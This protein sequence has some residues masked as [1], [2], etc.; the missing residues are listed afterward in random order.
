MFLEIHLL[1]KIHFRLPVFYGIWAFFDFCKQP[2]SAAQQSRISR[3]VKSI[4]NGQFW[5]SSEQRYSALLIN[6]DGYPRR[7]FLLN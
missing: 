2:L 4:L 6:I 7:L 5:G 3:P 1:L